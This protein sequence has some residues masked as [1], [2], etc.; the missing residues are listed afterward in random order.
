MAAVGNRATHFGSERSAM[1]SKA[2]TLTA[3]K[4]ERFPDYPPRDDMQNW[5]YLYDSGVLS[6][7]TVHF[8]GVPT[9]TVASEV[10]VGPQP[11]LAG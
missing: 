8:A 2:T 1:T 6:A 3:G 10:P 5:L 9:V 7:L 11:A 4:L